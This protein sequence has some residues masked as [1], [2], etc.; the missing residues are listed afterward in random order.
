[1]EVLLEYLK[2]ISL[3]PGD[4]LLLVLVFYGKAHKQWAFGFLDENEVAAVDHLED[5]LDVLL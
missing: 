1:L 3:R 4:A 2:Q 5:L